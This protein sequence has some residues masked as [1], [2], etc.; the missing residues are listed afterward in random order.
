MKNTK[1]NYDIYDN[2]KREIESDQIISGIWARAISEA[3]GCKEKAMGLYIRYRYI[4]I[5]EESAADTGRL[6]KAAIKSKLTSFLKIS[7]A[8]FSVGLF[9][10]LALWI[11]WLAYKSFTF[12]R[13]QGAGYDVLGFILIITASVFGYTAW[14]IYCFF[15]NN[16]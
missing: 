5:T 3:L 13:H 6:R 9:S 15:R 2:I 7:E 14:R 12:D 4:Q 10:F 16:W 11:S 8:F 1:V